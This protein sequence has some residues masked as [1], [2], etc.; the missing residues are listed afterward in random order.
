MI[1]EE[2]VKEPVPISSGP[3]V[4]QAGVW[5]LDYHFNFI[6]IPS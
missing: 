3:T 5:T 1:E 2:M 6:L 4:S